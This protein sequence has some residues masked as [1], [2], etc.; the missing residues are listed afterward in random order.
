VNIFQ[1]NPKRKVLETT[2]DQSIGNEA[3]E[4]DPLVI[5]TSTRERFFVFSNRLPNEDR[6][7]FN[8]AVVKGVG[9]VVGQKASARLE[10]PSG[11]ILHTTVGD[12]RIELFSKKCP[13]TVE[14]FSVHARDGYYNN[15]VF[16]RVIRGF[17]IQTGD[18]ERGDGTGGRSIYG[19]EFE[20]E[21]Y[22]DLRHSEPFM[23]SMANHGPNTN[24]SQFFITTVPCPW[25]DGK[26]TLFGR[27]VGGVDTVKEIENLE[28]DDKDR[29][30]IDVRI[31]EIKLHK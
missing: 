12:I 10:R 17:M 29:P 21:I 13:K 9:A 23:V 4:L 22:E 14:N 7:V 11:A 16:H 28:T 18:A 3:V 24:G 27:V 1:G 2:G 6:D 25:L 31:I 5:A 30:V 20:D 15:V 8:D 26:H 19:R